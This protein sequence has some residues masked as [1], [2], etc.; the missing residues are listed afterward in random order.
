MAFDAFL[1][2]DGIKGESKDSKHKDHFDLLSFSWGVANTG[3]F[4]AGGGGGT[5][6]VSVGDLHLTMHQ[7]NASPKLNVACCSGE[8]FAKATLYVR[9]AGKEQIEFL[10][11]DLEE[12]L[13]SSY[14]SGG[15]A[16]GDGHVVDQF[17]LNFGKFKHTYKEQKPDGSAGAAIVAG[18]DVQGKKST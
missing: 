2:I 7:N 12:V 15:S 5:G 1:K 13:I 10:T 16:G 8:H 6:V 4:G 17:S 18:W 14:S 3:S 9:K 11:V